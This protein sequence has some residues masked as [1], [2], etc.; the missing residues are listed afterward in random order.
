[1]C[2]VD[3]L[4]EPCNDDDDTSYGGYDDTYFGGYD[5]T[6]FGG[7]DDTYFGG[8]DDITYGGGRK[9]KSRKAQK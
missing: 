1:L 9:L 3:A 8:Y 2:S 5:D 6:Y 7:Y 4:P